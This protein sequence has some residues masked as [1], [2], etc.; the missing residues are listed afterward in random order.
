MSVFLHLFLVVNH[1]HAMLG[2]GRR[3]P[4]PGD[5]ACEFARSFAGNFLQYL[6]LLLKKKSEEGSKQMSLFWI[7]IKIIVANVTISGFVPPLLWAFGEGS[8]VLPQS[9]KG[10]ANCL[11]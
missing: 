5:A 8:S 4:I 2:S 1:L 11:R 10:A 6:Q 9:I 3:D 7:A